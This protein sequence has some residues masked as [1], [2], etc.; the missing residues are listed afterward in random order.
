MKVFHKCSL[1]FDLDVESFSSFK[2]YRLICVMLTVAILTKADEC[3]QSPTTASGSSA[4]QQICS[5][6]LIFHEPFDNLDKQKWNPLV[7]FW[8]G[9][10]S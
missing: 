9:G 6:Q 5:G 10:V 8:D 3:R 7:T 1:Q 4:P 2:M